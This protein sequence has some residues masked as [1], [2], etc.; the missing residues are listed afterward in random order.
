MTSLQTAAR[1]GGEPGPAGAPVVVP[2]SR[3]APCRLARQ[4]GARE[5]GPCPPADAQRATPGPI[6]REFGLR[7]ATRL[8]YEGLERP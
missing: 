1:D 8:W 5:R 3:R 7:A 2:R 4:P 6:C